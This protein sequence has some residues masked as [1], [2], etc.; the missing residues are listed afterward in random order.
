MQRSTRLSDSTSVEALPHATEP[1]TAFDFAKLRKD[2]AIRREQ[3]VAKSLTI[4]LNGATLDVL[5]DCPLKRSLAKE[6][7]EIK[8]V[9]DDLGRI[10]R[11]SSR[12]PQSVTSAANP[13]KATLNRQAFALT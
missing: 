3:L 4:S 1:F 10:S 9:G 6:D 5:Y 12:I 8:A 13:P 11:N 2:C 7:H